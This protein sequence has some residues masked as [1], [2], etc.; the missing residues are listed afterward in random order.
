MP[1][2]SGRVEELQIKKL[3][4]CVRTE[5][6]YQIKKLCEKGVEQLI[7]YNEPAEGETALILAATMN[8]DR[9]LQFLLDIGAHPNV[10]DFQV[11]LITLIAALIAV[12]E[13]LKLLNREELL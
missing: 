8:N 6:F 5:D 4:H 12:K 13:D 3:L 1:T 11:S 9:M 10:T 7:N 2:A